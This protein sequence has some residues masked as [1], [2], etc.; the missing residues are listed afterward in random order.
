MA[1]Q[2]AVLKCREKI[3][4]LLGDM[5]VSG[6]AEAYF[7][8]EKS[9][10]ASTFNT[11]GL[12]DP[13]TLNCDD[14]LAVHLL[15][16]DFKPITVRRLLLPGEEKHQVEELLS[17]IDPGT[18]L[19]D[20]GAVEALDCANALW[21]YL[22]TNKDKF[23]GV[24]WVTAGKILARKRPHLIPILDRHVDSYLQPP[25]GE[26]WEV[27]GAALQEGE[28]VEQI[29]RLRPKPVSSV[30]MRAQV[31]TIRLLDV[32]IWMHETEG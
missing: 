8:P 15:G 1:D 24:D 13:Y 5:R 29:E 2:E 14:L 30:E 31:S 22:K 27:L 6:W 25:K 32:A 12:N 18:R 17:T 9:W 10:T 16:I 19:W 4:D 11:L 20:A 28:L 3:K 21:L 23:P 26:F 7:N